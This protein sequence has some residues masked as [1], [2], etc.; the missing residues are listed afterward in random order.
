MRPRLVIITE[1]IAPYRVPVFNSLAARGD[2]DL[3][4]VFLA[5]TDP[6][7]RQWT[8]PKDEIRFSYQVLPSF[9]LRLG[10]SNLLLNRG[11]DR[12]LRQVRPD[13][14]VCGGYNYPSAW[15][16]AFW[17][18]ERNI[19]FLLWTE[20]NAA[21]HRGRSTFVE[22]LKRKYLGMC[23]GFVVPGE[24]SK[25]YL[26]QLGLPAELIFKAPDAVENE[27]FTQGARMARTNLATVRKR[28]DV[29]ER[30]FLN[31][32][33]LI[34][35]KGVF[36]LLEAYAKLDEEIRASVG[37]VFVGEGD[38]KSELIRRASLIRPGTVKVSLFVQKEQ[39]A[40]FYALADAFVFPTHSDPWGLVV[41]EAMASGLPV[42][43]SNVAGC[44]SDLVEDG[45]NGF[46]VPVSDVR[47]IC[48]SMELLA[49]GNDLRGQMGER[50]LQRIQEYS[51]EA[52]A[53]GIAKAAFAVC[54]DV[55]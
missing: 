10:N 44:V 27:L 6:K 51:P 7:L 39:L 40:E 43:A 26:Q 13:V 5:E 19:P 54:G 21:D 34:R 16:A 2:V 8:V 41:N 1:I 23:R 42:I 29:P 38:A 14:I 55:S 46:I 45:W 12:A 28:I 33:R 3:H 17:A 4:V 11:L 53:A 48:S 50:S 32:G 18:R 35:A 9:R 22:Y 49:K 30:Y 31:V 52:C 36:D 20:S 37:L 47:R 25:S 24:A 15:R